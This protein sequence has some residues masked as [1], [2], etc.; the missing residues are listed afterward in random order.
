MQDRVDAIARAIEVLLARRFDELGGRAD[1]IVG[2]VGRGIQ[3]SRTPAMHEREATRIGLSC[4]YVLIDFD[5]MGLADADIADALTAA[6]KVGFNGVNVTYPYKQM[7]MPLLDE[8]APE[9]R[10]IGAVNT[11]VFGPRTIG[12]NTD[13][14]GFAESFRSQMDG[15]VLG[16]AIM[17]G[18]GGAGSAVGAALIG[19]GARQIAIVDTDP[20]RADDLAGRLAHMDA[21]TIVVAQDIRAA[22]TAA[23]GIVNTT[24]IGMAKHP[25]TPFPKEWLKPHQWV[26][27]I[28]YFP[29]ETELLRHARE[30]GCRTLPGI[31]MAIGQA[32]R[33]FEH[34]TGRPADMAAMA[35]HFEAAA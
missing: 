16:S 18:A 10:M 6:A 5:A 7:V 9:A 21:A 19:L 33:A 24:P 35:G 22:I 1:V 13:Y 34:F 32:V 28:I 11:V 4:A 2:L 29:R 31:G 26:A 27:D 25:G 20:S 17:F 12:Y 8:V 3:L 14:W 15:A 23:D 30:I